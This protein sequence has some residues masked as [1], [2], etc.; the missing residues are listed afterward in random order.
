MK[1][2]SKSVR[3]IFIWVTLVGLMLL[4][5]IACM[6][7][8]DSQDISGAALI[9]PG[10]YILTAKHS[11]M[12]LDLPGSNP[13]AG[14]QLWQY[15]LNN[16]NAQKWKLETL[17]GEW[18]KITSLVN[19]LALHAGATKDG[20]K[21]SL[22]PYSNW[23]AKHWRL[24]ARG[25]YYEIINRASSGWLEVKDASTAQGSLVQTWSRTYNDNQRWK[26]EKVDALSDYQKNLQMITAASVRNRNLDDSAYRNTP[27]ANIPTG[28]TSPLLGPRSDYLQ[29]AGGNPE[30]GF[31]ARGVGTFRTSCEFS[32]FAYDDPLV[33]PNK[34]GAAHLHMFWGNTDVNAYSTYDTLYN[35]GSSTCNGMELNRTGYWAPAMFDAKG[36]VRIPERVIVYYK[37]Y[38]LAQGKSIIYPPRAAMISDDKLHRTSDTVGGVAE[39]NFLCSDQ[40][41]GQRTPASLTI[42]IC[43]GS[44]AINLWGSGRAAIEMHI[45]FPNCWNRQD[46]SNPKNWLLSRAGSWFYS[47]CEERATLPNIHYIIAYPLEPNETTAGWYIASDV[48]PTTR[49]RTKARGSS[50]HADWWGAWNPS[51]NKRWIDNCVNSKTDRNGDGLD[52]EDHGCGFGY[53]TNGGP[54]VRLDANGNP[55]LDANGNPIPAPPLPGP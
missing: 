43:N 40:F 30:V 16:S 15:P 19:G 6:A 34:P 38:G 20:A 54:E 27:M 52:D 1:T 9:E 49:Q 35:S 33:H 46:P 45:K 26:L 42:P 22:H 50:I 51:I 25:G 13:Q 31:P 55:V 47:N 12:V 14:V 3:K 2:Y 32:H 23:R 53:L 29:S 17:D 28:S 8:Q 48:D 18:V 11:G 7:E 44:S 39:M 24:I 10:T 5:L 41:R 4:G 36:N 37:G 21:V